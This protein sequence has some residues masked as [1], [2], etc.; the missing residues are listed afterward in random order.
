MPIVHRNVRYN[1]RVFILNKKILLIRPKLFLADDGNYRESRWF[2][3]WKHRCKTEPFYLPRLIRSITNQDQVPFGEACLAFLDTV[4]AS[5]SCEELFTPD[6][7]HAFY[8]LSG[9]EIF[10]NGSG[11]HHQ[12]RKLNKRVELIKNATSKCGG[13]YIY[14]NHQCCDGGRLYFDGCSMIAS[15]GN[16]LVQGSQ[17]S[18][19]EVEVLVANVDLES[20]RTMRG[21]FK[22]LSEQSSS[23]HIS[24]PRI[25]V[26]F[27][28]TQP[29]YPSSNIKS[30]LIPNK[31]IEA[32][33][34]QFEEEIGLGPACWLWD[35]LRRSDMSGFF[36]PLSGGADSS[37]TASI[38]AIMCQ[39]VMDQVIKG[40]SLVISDIRRIGRYQ[41][42]DL[43]KNSKE[44]CSRIF[45]TC[46]MQSSNSSLSTKL[47]ALNL[48]KEIGSTHFE[49]NIDKIVE[50]FKEMALSTFGKTPTFKINGGSNT[51]NLALQNIQARSR[52]V[53]SYLLAQL[54]LWA[55]EDCSKSLLVLGSSNVDESLRGYMTKYDCSSADINP[56]G[57]ISKLDLRRFL[58]WASI[59]YQW[60]SLLDVLK[61]Q[62]TAELEPITEDYV[63][64][65]EQDMG[66][67]YEELSVFGELRKIQYCG[68]LSMFQQLC[69]IWT[70]LTPSIIAQK[71]KS[72]FYYYS[73]NRH[74]L[75]TLT[76]S[77]HA[78][79]YSPDDNRFDLR[80]FLI[81]SKWT[82]QFKKID[83]LVS[84]MDEGRVLV[85][86][87]Q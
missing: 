21:S 74:K 23:D 3:S 14:A 57:S 16:I 45:F 81:N 35:Y 72:F 54:S 1:C 67:T 26:D 56:I 22:A 20:V 44:I 2:S 12:L 27:S 28:L 86:D 52:M 61:A 47:R 79:N 11:S 30:M 55:S 41:Q 80:P 87:Y 65:D 38:V 36:L 19:N 5:E 31:P 39:L 13:I 77:Y 82:W 58:S 29:G 59:K 75:T 32:K 64:N 37:S 69:Y 42:N 68:P 85:V 48:S 10:T 60:P 17:F 76:P 34:H 71:V 43:P 6:S 40:N 63:Q 25:T 62:P 33:F 4:L 49:V 83:V 8:S 24:P 70:H 73:I 7:P 18:I 78:D 53:I 46:Y 84:Q 51:E 66:M 9:V 15:N 50:S